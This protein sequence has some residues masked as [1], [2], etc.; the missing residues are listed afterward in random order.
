MTCWQQSEHLKV[1][2]CLATVQ[3][4]VFAHFSLFW[5]HAHTPEEKNLAFIIQ[6]APVCPRWLFLR[7]I[8][9]QVLSLVSSSLLHRK[10]MYYSWVRACSSPALL[11]PP[12]SDSPPDLGGWHQDERIFFWPW[13][14][15][16]WGAGVQHWPGGVRERHTRRDH[17]RFG[18]RQSYMHAHFI[19]KRTEN[20]PAL[21]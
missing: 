6:P 16:S 7:C 15:C 10:R 8:S 14:L 19:Y 3:G 11:P 9:F 5:M 13:H 12:G 17:V 20:K 2:Q 4:C 21:F 18:R 1:K